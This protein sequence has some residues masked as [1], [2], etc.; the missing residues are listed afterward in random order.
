MEFGFHMPV[1]LIFGTGAV[2]NNAKKL[3]LG[4]KALIVTG[5][6]S[7]RISGALDDVVSVL[8]SENIDYYVFDGVMNNPTLENVSKGASFGRENGADFIIAIGGGSPMDAAKA[9]AALMTNDMNPIDLISTVPKNQSLPIAA[10]P[11][12]SGT[13]SEVTPYSILTVHSMNTKK[14]FYSPSSFPRVAFADPAYTYSLPYEITL[15]TA[16]DAFSHLLESYLSKRSNYFNDVIAI[17]GMKAFAECMDALNTGEITEKTRESL[18]YSSCLGGVAITHTG[19][20]I[21]HAM[22]YSLTYFKGYSHGR[23]NAMLIGSYLDFNRTAQPEKV[24]K[25]LSILGFESI[26]EVD[27]YFMVG[28]DK[29]PVLDDGEI[30][31]FTGLAMGQGSV[32]Q[33]PRTVKADDI[34]KLYRELFG[35]KG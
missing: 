35:G 26:D 17:E 8:T 12:T 5:R 19:T 31:K 32:M 25:V 28:M 13:G 23:A 16:F 27:K 14:N 30:D 7:A 4:S 11:T 22:G 10:I 15:D 24:E 1:D 34:N 9:I 18:M 2:S 3:V 33:N 21:I 20:T 6:N 29:R